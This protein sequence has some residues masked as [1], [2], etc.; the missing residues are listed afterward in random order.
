M[1]ISFLLRARK[2]SGY[3]LN[4]KNCENSSLIDFGFLLVRFG[5][6]I[7]LIDACEKKVPLVCFRRD[8]NVIIYK[9]I[10]VLS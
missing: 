2:R 6:G 4:K 1:K 10:M 8:Q 7:D 3:L 5:I 9:N